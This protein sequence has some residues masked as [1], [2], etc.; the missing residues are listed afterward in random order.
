[1]RY[2]TRCLAEH[3]LSIEASRHADLRDIVL[4]CILDLLGA[5][6]AGFDLPAPTAMRTAARTMFG[7]GDA[8]I[9]RSSPGAA[10][11]A[12]VVCNVA[13][14]SALDI[15][16]GHRAARG[17]PGACVIPTVLTLASQNSCAADDIF[18]AI[19]AG[20]DI[21]VRVAA[22]QTTTGIRTRQ[23]G[24][25]AG[26]AAA[27][28]AGRLLRLGPQELSHAFAIAGVLGPNQLANGSSG[29][30]RLP[31][32]DVKE[33]IPWGAATG[34]TA[35]CLAAGGHTGPEDIFDDPHYYDAGRILSEMGSKWE[36][37]GTYFKP[38][39]CCR[40]IHPALDA[41]LEVM[42]EAQLD[43]AE[44]SEVEVQTFSWALKLSNMLEP[45]SLVEVQ[46]SLPY[47]LAVAAI[48]G[49]E[50]LVPLTIACLKRPDL[51][52]FAMK[53][54]ITT[55]PDL[56]VLFPSQTVARVI[57]KAHDRA[58]WSNIQT[59]LGDPQR[60]M[61][62]EAIEQKFRIVTR[63]R[64]SDLKRTSIIDGVLALSNGDCDTLLR[65][66]NCSE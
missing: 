24:R 48:D 50:A 22:A 45:G 52:E 21:G 53:V 51:A 8:P 19:I 36:I 23:S 31:G 64:L 32:N 56:D 25:W 42:R 54:R 55:D 34:L 20:Y 61:N 18:A 43:A 66:L 65:A 11:A 7:S 40:Y 46:Y 57:I 41:L 1:M 63:H 9:W 26:I 27:A 58:F 39:A 13:A 17:H 59:P 28:A 10:P 12:A 5:A 44:I 37:S 2:V 16:D 15:D 6:I 38:Y 4:R 29:Y 30:S 35:V 47:C 3:A 49:A 60:P 33:G 14:A 62:W